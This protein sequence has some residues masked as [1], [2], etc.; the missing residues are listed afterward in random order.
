MESKLLSLEIKETSK[1]IK[2]IRILFGILCIV[3][4]VYW[5]LFNIRSAKATGNLWITSSFLVAFGVYQLLSGT[6][7]TSKFIE[8][9]VN[10]IRLKNNSLLPP[11]EISTDQIEKVELLPLCLVFNLKPA[12]KILLRFGITY[13]E[14]NELIKNE[15]VNYMQSNKIPLEVKDEQ[16]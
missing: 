5:I 12:K 2:V 4:A 13:P 9:K 11:V 3:I 7:Y 15:I 10:K 16:V 6:G 14:R 1:V 8:L